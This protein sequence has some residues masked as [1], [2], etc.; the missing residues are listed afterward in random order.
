VFD[1]FSSTKGTMAGFFDQVKSGL[2]AIV[3]P[4]RL[5]FGAVAAGVAAA[6]IAMS[7]YLDQQNKVAMSL[8]GIGRA[9]G[10]SISGINAISGQG[11]SM[12]G[13][14]VSEARGMATALAATG[15][16]ANDN[17]LPIVQMGKDIATAFGVDAADATKLLAKA[18]SDPAKGAEELNQRLGFLDAAM[19]RNIQNLQGQGRL[20][21]AQ[22]VLAAG[23]ASSLTD[24][25]AAVSTSTKFW[26]ALGNGVSFVWDK[27]G[28]G[29][30]RLTGIGFTA[31]LNEQIA[32]TKA[33]IEELQK[34]AA[35]RS[36]FVN[37][38]LGT[39]GEIERQTTKY[40]EQTAALQ[41]LTQASVD[42]QMR[43]RSFAVASAVD[44]Y[45]PEIAA[46][47]K[48]R[49]E[50][51]LLVDTM[52]DVQ[53]TGGALSPILK[54]MGL[55]YEQFAQAVA[56]AS[57]E[58]AGFK[59]QADR[60]AESLKIGIAAVG[61][62]SPGQLGDIAARQ[63]Y[64][65]AGQNPATADA[66]TKANAE[67]SRT[68]AIAQATRQITDAN[69]ERLLSAK[70]RVDTA[71]LELGILGQG[72]V[73][74][75]RQRSI[76]QAKQQLE[77][78]A[79]RTYGSRD[80]Y[81][82][83]HLAALTAQIDAEAKLKQS[84]VEQQA[85]RDTTFDRSQIGRTSD[86]QQV[87]TKLRSIYGDNNY[88]SEMNGTIAASMRLNQQLQFTHDLAGDALKGMVSDMRNGV[89][90]AQAF[91]NAM[92]G[93]LNKVT[94]K[95]LDMALNKVWASAFGGTSGGGLMSFLGLGGVQYGPGGSAGAG[96]VGA[97]GPTLPG[98]DVGG[99][100]G[101][102][103]K[104]QP[105]GIVH[106]GE[107]VFD[108]GAVSRIGLTNLAMMH[109]G[110]ADG[111]YVGSPP[112]VPVMPHQMASGSQP[113][114]NNFIVE[115]HADADVQEQKQVNS[116]GGI[117]H[118]VIIRQAVKDDLANGSLQSSLNARARAPQRLTR[119]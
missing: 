24:V 61:A 69:N 36:D 27:I 44:Q 9:S 118:R 35:N 103:G 85:L 15:R 65:S 52:I 33:R 16:V 115:N 111:G 31:G 62:R 71:Q 59:S 43:Q 96:Y 21:E 57:A 87:T 99:Y 47:Q 34:I 22:K 116:S 10:A 46:L 86:E 88:E 90:A 48:L 113:V 80:A 77:Q 41:K 49:N 42:A 89:P 45:S 3:T 107:Y 40:N 101:P 110:Y 5:A 105:A 70:Q 78:D 8:T 11:S 2:G 64:S 84:L 119:R 91:G 14:S 17:I 66:Q 74:Q 30:S 73:E 67:L 37:K 75:D 82:R 68:L 56:K 13:L 106:R 38:G 112:I 76:L 93:M 26:T 25:N 72:V 117:D 109:R 81:D 60:T 95:L 104:Y 12:F 29:A 28:E 79:L 102:G 63:F 58:T 4:A 92:T 19:Q 1:I 55:S 98:F 97:T 54:A 7:Q 108:Q 53:T 94:D 23:A 32:Q 100:T 51:T 83:S 6:T 50:Q 20:W 39:T 114:T 18:F